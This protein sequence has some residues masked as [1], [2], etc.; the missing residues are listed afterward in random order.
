MIHETSVLKKVHFPS[1]SM[2]DAKKKRLYHDL[3]NN[4]VSGVLEDL[5]FKISEGSD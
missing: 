2:G 4:T 3:L 1:T 5:K